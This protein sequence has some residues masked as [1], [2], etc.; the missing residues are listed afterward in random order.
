[1]SIQWIL[2]LITDGQIKNAFQAHTYH[3]FVGNGPTASWDS[4]IPYPSWYQIF[5]GEFSP[6]GGWFRAKYRGYYMFTYR[7]A[8]SY[9][10]GTYNYMRTYLTKYY[11]SGYNWYSYPISHMLTRYPSVHTSVDL[12][13]LNVND[14]VWVTIYRYVFCDHLGYEFLSM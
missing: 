6:W 3:A 5:G 13:Y 8:P 1:M 11:K 12:V 14:Y 7:I 10:C 9:V 2:F 4:R